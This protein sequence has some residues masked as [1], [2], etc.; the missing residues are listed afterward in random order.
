M[1]NWCAF[2]WRRRHMSMGVGCR[3]YGSKGLT[4]YNRLSTLSVT[5]YNMLLHGDG[6]QFVN[7]QANWATCR[8]GEK[9][10]DR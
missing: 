7:M 10:I 3:G 9:Q 6:G 1:G 2:S 4:K 8:S 5:M